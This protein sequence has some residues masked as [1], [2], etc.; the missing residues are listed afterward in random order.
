MKKVTFDWKLR[1]HRNVLLKAL[2]FEFGMRKAV[3]VRPPINDEFSGT[4]WKRCHPI[5]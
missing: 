3:L 1:T 5:F 4:K 2:I